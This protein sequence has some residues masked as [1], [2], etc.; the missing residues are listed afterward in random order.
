MA[1]KL[2]DVGSSLSYY[3][4][5]TVPNPIAQTGDR[6]AACLHIA[7]VRQQCQSIENVLLAKSLK[8]RTPLTPLWK[9]AK[10][11]NWSNASKHKIQKFLIG[12]ELQH[13]CSDTTIN[14]PSAC[15]NCNCPSWFVPSP[16]VAHGRLSPRSLSDCRVSL[17]VWKGL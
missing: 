8:I 17:D 6:L 10:V 2:L 5:V 7:P 9:I 1:T 11:K 13:H 14:L 15:T 16:I 3:G 12:N 4:P